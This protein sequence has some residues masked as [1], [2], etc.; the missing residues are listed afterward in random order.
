MSLVPVVIL[1]GF[2]FN[3]VELLR[4]TRT[5]QHSRLFLFHELLIIAPTFDTL[6]Y[7][8]IKAPSNNTGISTNVLSSYMRHSYQ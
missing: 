5:L 6:Q 4:N 8:Q 7:V 2:S 1:I 3:M